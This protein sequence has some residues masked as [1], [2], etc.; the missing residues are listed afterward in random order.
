[1]DKLFK[2]N[3]KLLRILLRVPRWAPVADLYAKL[4]TLQIRVLHEMLML[5]FVHEYVHHRDLLPDI[6]R[7]YLFEN[8][9]IRDH[10]MRGKSDFHIFYAASGFGQR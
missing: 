2:L 8:E 7:N 9:L 10:K 5:I 4:S 6:F 1:M 3:N